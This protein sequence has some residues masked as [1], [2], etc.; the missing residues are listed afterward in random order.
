MIGFQDILNFVVNFSSK[1]P[2]L[3]RAFFPGLS[4]T[5]R[6]RILSSASYVNIAHLRSAL[7]L[8]KRDLR[9]GE[10]PKSRFSLF[11]EFPFFMIVSSPRL[12]S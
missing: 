8:W 2:G 11:W 7:R 12:F 3:L 4:I 10:L 9:A 5:Y 6:G 1:S